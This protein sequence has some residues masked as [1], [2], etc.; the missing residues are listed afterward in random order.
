MAFRLNGLISLDSAS[1]ILQPELSANSVVVVFCTVCNPIT[2]T[3][4]YEQFT[5]RA[6]LLLLF[7]YH[8]LHVSQNIK[9]KDMCVKH[10]NFFGLQV[11][12]MK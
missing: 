8:N 3:L 5:G 12:G 4:L 9:F 6:I 10:C 1:V 7:F 2:I 11:S